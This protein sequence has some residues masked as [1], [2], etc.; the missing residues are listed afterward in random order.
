MKRYL[1]VLV[2]C[3]GSLARTTFADEVPTGY[4]RQAAE[5]RALLTKAMT[6]YEQVG[7]KAF[8]EFNRQG[9]FTSQALYI[10]VVD[11]RGIMLASGGPSCCG[12]PSSVAS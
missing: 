9:R 1:P 11:T 6:R 8:A 10:Y 3:L 4:E 5:A 7:D 2:F 12:I